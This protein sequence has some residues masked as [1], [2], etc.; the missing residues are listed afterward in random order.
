MS[1]ALTRDFSV[2][3]ATGVLGGVPMNTAEFARRAYLYTANPLRNPFKEVLDAYPTVQA[4]PPMFG[5]FND[6]PWHKLRED[7]VAAWAKAGISFVIADGEHSLDQGRFGREANAMLLRHGILPV[8]RLH[9]E[10]RS[11]HGDH[12]TLGSRATMRPYATSIEQVN[13]YL[14][15]VKYP[16]PGCATQNSRGGFPMRTGDREMIFTPGALRRAETETQA[17]VQFETEE[18]IRAGETRDAVLRAMAA[19]GR[20]KTCGFVGPFDALLR[21]GAG[22]EGE[23]QATGAGQAKRP[24]N[25]EIDELIAGAAE[26]GIHMGRVCGSGSCSEPKQIEDAMVAAIN[27]G[28]RIISSHYLTSDLPY[29]GASAVAAPFFAAC[30]RC[31]F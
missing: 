1:D 8:Q 6:I 18:L 20:N 9:R 3:T 11:E 23:E 16:V 2:A 28:S 14:E 27:N 24:I 26:L 10:A 5:I 15:C 7:E 12:L 30:A 29:H 13:D 4:C 22:C 17:W 25:D 21:S 19:E 31:G